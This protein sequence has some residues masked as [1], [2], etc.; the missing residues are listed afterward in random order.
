MGA[1]TVSATAER[2]ELPVWRGRLHAGAFVLAIPLAVALLAVAR[3]AEARA[4]AAVYAATLVA[5]FGTSA[6][7]HRLVAS[8]RARQWMRRADHSTI[9]LLIAGT[10][11]PICLLALPPAWGVPVLVVVWLG[12]LVGVVLKLAAF[13]RRWVRTAGWTLYL[14]LGWV[15]VLAAPAM[16]E[17]LTAAELILIVIGGLIYTAGSVVLATGRP[18]PAPA[19]FGYHE[20]WHA[21]TV[22]AGLC[23]FASVGLV[24]ASAS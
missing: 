21:C 9:Y 23:H 20:V 11:T 12:A 18:D 8:P 4:A 7:Y 13:D 1:R 24:V 17:H 10:Y 16:L 15:A 6:A 14:V 22:L 3:P 19:V 2:A 5:G